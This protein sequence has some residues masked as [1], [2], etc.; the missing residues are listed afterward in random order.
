MNRW[1]LL[2]LAVALI[3]SFGKVSDAVQPP[4]DGYWEG[5]AKLPG[6][7]MRLTVNFKTETGNIKGTFE[8]PDSGYLPKPPPSLVNILAKDSHVHFEIPKG[9]AMTVPYDGEI[10]GNT[11][12]GTFQNGK[13]NGAFMLKRIVPKP[14]PY[15]EC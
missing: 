9:G 14:P 4:I 7:D 6:D 3:C 12:S 11:I 13:F 2:L 15:K 5:V 1:V 10:S 8:I